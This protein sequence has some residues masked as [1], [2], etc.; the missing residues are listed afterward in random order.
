MLDPITKLLTHRSLSNSVL[1]QYNPIILMYHGTPMGKPLSNYSIGAGKFKAHLSYL[2]SNGW[3][4]ILFR[5]LLSADVSFP[6][7]TIVLTFDDGYANN[8]DGAFV[9]LVECGMKATWFITTNCIGQK[10][11]WQSENLGEAEML[12]KA[13]LQKMAASG[14]EIASHTCSHPDLSSLSYDR[15]FEEMQASKSQLETLIQDAV[16]SL[17][18]PFGKFNDKSVDAAR[19]AGYKIACT[20]HSGSLRPKTNPMLV[21][22]ITIYRGDSVNRLARKLIFAD[23][24]VPLSKIATY[25]IKR[26]KYKLSCDT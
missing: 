14:M 5:D 1:F 6:P 24:E 10:A 23:N 17:A 7:K 22:R 12:T 3:H 4:S 25:Y 9:P 19:A 2:K 21:P 26:I 18:Y 20:T 13:Q 16:T 15:Q 8:F 11:H